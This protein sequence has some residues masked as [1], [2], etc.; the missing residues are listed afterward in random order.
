MSCW[1][2]A[3]LSEGR[4]RDLAW[5]PDLRLFM[6]ATALPVMEVGP[7][8]FWELRRLASI[9]RRVDMVA[10][11]VRASLGLAGG[12]ACPTLRLAR[13]SGEFGGR[14]AASYRSEE[15]RGGE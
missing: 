7:V 14:M 12:S 15:R 6:E 11:G 10:P 13:R 1:R 2:S 9:C 8:D 3:R 5:M 4:R